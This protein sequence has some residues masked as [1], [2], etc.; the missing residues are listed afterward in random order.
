MW[1]W[2]IG[3]LSFTWH[4]VRYG[5]FHKGWYVVMNAVTLPAG[6]ILAWLLLKHPDWT[7]ASQSLANF[8][9]ICLIPIGL[10]VAFALVRLLV[11]PYV[12]YSG[13]QKEHAK[14]VS[15]ITENHKRDLGVIT[16]ERDA[17]RAQVDE[18][19]AIKK[20][21]PQPIFVAIDELRILFHQGEAL[22]NKFEI[23]EWEKPTFGQCVAWDDEVTACARQQ[24]FSEIIRPDD[25][26]RFRTDWD[27]AACRNA[28]ARLDSLELLKNVDGVGRAVYRYVWGRVKR[29][30]ELL[31]KIDGKITPPER[32]PQ[33]VA[34]ALDELKDMEREGE[35]ML[36]NAFLHGQFPTLQELGKY[37]AK[38][39]AAVRQKVFAP[40][41]GGGG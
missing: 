35:R 4:C 14:H 5:L 34:V 23:P 8:I 40:H 1:K 37:R 13:L 24:V 20:K 30:E 39:L 3:M 22:A 11:S 15:D 29:L 6:M 28:E 18:L 16:G 41:G 36:D 38:T 2:F 31:A 21:E 27:N 7:S 26:A 25:M 17:L 32:E 19:L 10:A 9:L 12:I 33:V